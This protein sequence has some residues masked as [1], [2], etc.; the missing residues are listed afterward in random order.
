M[1][2]VRLPPPGN[3]RRVC[4]DDVVELNEGDGYMTSYK[5]PLLSNEHFS[6]LLEVLDRELK[7]NDFGHRFGRLLRSPS[8]HDSHPWLERPEWG[9]STP[10]VDPMAN[11]D[12]RHLELSSGEGGHP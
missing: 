12:C 11:S 3:G 9:A 1:A 7:G 5:D 4:F 10:S 6:G 2:R 8:F